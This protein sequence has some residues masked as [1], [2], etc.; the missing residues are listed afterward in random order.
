MAIVLGVAGKG[1]RAKGRRQTANGKR[2]KAER[3]T[4]E[5]NKKSQRHLLDAIGLIVFSKVFSE[6]ARL[7]LPF[8][9]CLL[10]S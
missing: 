10:P 8:A 7:F 4:A 6:F 9:V 1:Q 2:Q 3:N 5:G